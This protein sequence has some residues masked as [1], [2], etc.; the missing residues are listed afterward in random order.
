VTKLFWEA[1]PP[2]LRHFVADPSKGSVHNRGCAADISLYDLQTGKPVKMIG[3]YDEMT[4]RSNR[5]YPGGTSHERWLRGLL[6]YALAIHQFTVYIYEWWHFDYVDQDK[7]P[8]G[9]VDFDKLIPN[10]K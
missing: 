9:N 7:Y 8:L 6:R 5:E 10:T 2:H 1:T 4:Q 3:G